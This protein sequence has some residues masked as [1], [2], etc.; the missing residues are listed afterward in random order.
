[1][2]NDE[3]TPRPPLPPPF[4]RPTHPGYLPAIHPE[5]EAGRPLRPTPYASAVI[6][7]PAT[8][9][10]PSGASVAPA[11]ATGCEKH[12]DGAGTPS[13]AVAAGQRQSEEAAG[14]RSPAHGIQSLR[15]LA[16]HDAHPAGVPAN[17]EPAVEAVDSV[18][19]YPADSTW[20]SDAV[21]GWEGEASTDDW[22]LVS[23]LPDRAPTAPGDA[24]SD[25]T[26]GAGA[27]PSDLALGAAGLL[28]ELAQAITRGDLVLP[29]IS[30]PQSAPAV[31]AAVL[32]ALLARTDDDELEA[33]EAP[34][35]EPRQ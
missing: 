13:P 27:R 5:S 6:P 18:S 30:W 26:S 23:G 29:S 2:P 4:S 14:E 34:A 15:G 25:R 31:L 28:E 33:Q 9:Q 1:M 20:S 3:S 8:D 16:P 17:P 11:E 7:Q 32:T 12:G 21:F 24:P 19:D 22:E 10:Q 35:P